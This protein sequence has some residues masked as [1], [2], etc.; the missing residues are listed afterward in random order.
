MDF[1]RN[2]NLN[3]NMNSGL[4]SIP[5]SVEVGMLMYI[6][7]IR[8]NKNNRTVQAEFSRSASV[9]FD[10]RIQIWVDWN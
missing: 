3:S 5:D 6:Q 9:L 10:Q 1:F 2:S 4:K 8:K 7:S